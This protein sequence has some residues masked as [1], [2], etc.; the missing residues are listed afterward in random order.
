M[1]TKTQMK[2]LPKWFNGDVYPKGGTV[3]NIFTGETA[4]LNS[5]ELSMYDFIMGATMILERTSYRSEKIINDH[6]RGLD[7]FRGANASAYMV[8]LD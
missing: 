8:L 6:R 4:E 7:W 5:N 3:K 1:S 2:P